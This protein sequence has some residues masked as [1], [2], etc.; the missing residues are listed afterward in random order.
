MSWDWTRDGQFAL[1]VERKGATV[2]DRCH[3]IVAVAKGYDLTWHRQQ[4][5]EAEAAL[6]PYHA[7]LRY[8]RTVRIPHGI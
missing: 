4:T 1:P 8:D 7:A 5:P 3:R 2:K 6:E